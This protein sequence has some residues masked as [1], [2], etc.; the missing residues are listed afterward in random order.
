MVSDGVLALESTY[1]RVFWGFGCVKGYKGS[2]CLVLE[3][4]LLMLKTLADL[5]TG[6]S[7]IVLLSLLIIY[8]SD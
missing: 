7:L 3:I 2:S 6:L 1:E 4:I 5:E 8:I